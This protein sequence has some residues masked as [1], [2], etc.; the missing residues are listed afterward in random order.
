MSHQNKKE[1]EQAVQKEYIRKTDINDNNSTTKLQKQ[2]T[3]CELISD[4]STF[5]KHEKQNTHWAACNS[6]TAHY[7][8]IC[9]EDSSK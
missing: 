4:K 7:E 9:S 5:T 2:H 6:E 8:C 3:H 1:V